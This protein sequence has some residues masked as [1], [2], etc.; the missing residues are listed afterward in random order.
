MSGYR[1]VGDRVKSSGIAG[2]QKQFSTV[3]NL[4]SKTVLYN[5]ERVIISKKIFFLHTW[6]T[7]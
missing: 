1:Q 3:Q 4:F 6:K 2:E 5:A 7:K